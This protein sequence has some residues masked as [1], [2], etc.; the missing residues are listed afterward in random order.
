MAK[1]VADSTLTDVFKPAKPR[2]K[3]T[4]GR[5]VQYGTSTRTVLSIYLLQVVLFVLQNLPELI[6]ADLNLFDLLYEYEYRYL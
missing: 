3:Y 5:L 6:L 4:C 1:Y 2:L